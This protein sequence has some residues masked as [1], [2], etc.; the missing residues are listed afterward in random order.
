MRFSMNAT[1]ISGLTCLFS[2][3]ALWAVHIFRP[4]LGF[5]GERIPQKYLVATAG[6]LFAIA[7]IS[8]ALLRSRGE[9]LGQLAWG[10][11]L[12]IGVFILIPVWGG[13]AAQWG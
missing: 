6:S 1:K 8:F 11:I 2:F 10:I 3:A 12:F 9:Y 5:G 4:Q 13:I 7:Y